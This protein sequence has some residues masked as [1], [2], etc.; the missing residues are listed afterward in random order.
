MAD[1]PK[2]VRGT[3]ANGAVVQT[4]EEN[5]E[6]LGA[7]FTPEKSSAQKATTRKSSSGDN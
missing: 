2:L 3:L 1:K 6:R 5:A 4:T 7:Q